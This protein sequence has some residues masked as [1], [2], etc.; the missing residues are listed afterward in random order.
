M[1]AEV[2]A[3]AAVLKALHADAAFMAGVNALY[4]GAPGRAAMPHGQVGEA[5]GSEWGGK[6]VDGREVRVTIALAVA[7]DSP[8]AL[9]PLIARVEPAIGAAA[10]IDGWRIVSA[11]LLRSR[12][13]RQGGGA[14]GWGAT[15]DYRLRVVREG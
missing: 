15:I 14:P 12:V 9:A 13:A 7:G 3:R 1:S 2:A 11:R 6:D 5:I 10:A 4:D 8:A